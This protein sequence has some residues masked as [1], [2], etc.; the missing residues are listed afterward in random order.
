MKR[1]LLLFLRMW[2]FKIPHEGQAVE[3]LQ[4]GG[5][6][7]RCGNEGSQE[8]PVLSIRADTRGEL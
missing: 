4:A 2:H 1:K 6:L 5:Y 8:K 3:L 7:K